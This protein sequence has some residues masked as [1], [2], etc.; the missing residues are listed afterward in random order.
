MPKLSQRERR[1][2]GNPTFIIII[3]MD[4]A[5]IQPHWTHT[6][7]E[8]FQWTDVK[9]TSEADKREVVVKMSVLKF[10]PPPPMSDEE[11]KGP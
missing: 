11:E 8:D 7:K 1:E 5:R 4:F 10:K 3:L 6:S 9:S 2:N